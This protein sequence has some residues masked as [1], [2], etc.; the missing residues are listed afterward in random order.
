MGTASPP[1]ALLPR[2]ATAPEPVLRAVPPRPGR[3]GSLVGRWLLPLLGLGVA[4]GVGGWLLAQRGLESTD[5]AQLQ[6]HLT[7]IASRI[8]GTIA[9]VLV[10]DDQ[11]VAAGDPLL[12]LDPRDAQARLR[13]AQAD[14]IQARQEAL[15]LRS[16]TGSST[17]L[18]AAALDQARG[19]G[20]AA[21]GELARAAA[22]V[23]RLETLVQQGGVSRQE[24]D[25]ARAGYSQARGAVLRGQASGRSAQASLDQVTVN[26]QKVAA[27][28][29]RILQAQA[30]LERARLDLSY[31][32]VV[33]PSA[34]RIGDRQAEPGSQVQPGQPLMT[35]VSGVPW[36][37]AHFK[38]TQLA[39]LRPGQPAE[40][41]VDA[42]PGRVFHGT[43]LGIAPASGARFTL[44]PPDNATGNFTKVVQRVTARI[45]LDPRELAAA[46][47]V[48]GLSVRV[49][50]RRP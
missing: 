27:A 21:E 8:P 28:E 30:A 50:V 42:F 11:A 26:R 13:Q 25:R 31:D 24:L 33:A 47:L 15:S 16:A 4:A 49:Q 6:A 22:D 40:V 36:V 43:V 37:E 23:R 44:L 1:S 41:R 7:V 29:A 5:D 39:A 38:E 34:G 35:L 12:L 46:H 3:N 14:L 45:G 19:E 20:I 2:E 32:R 17:N 10:E 18:A 9:R 48:P